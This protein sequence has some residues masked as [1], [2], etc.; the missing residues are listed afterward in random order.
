M[1]ALT[2]LPTRVSALSFSFQAWVPGK[3]EVGRVSPASNC[4][5]YSVASQMALSTEL[6]W[7]GGGELGLFLLLCPLTSYIHVPI[8]QMK[9][10]A[11]C[12]KII[13]ISR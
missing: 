8:V 9:C 13:K 1:P 2:I 11:P 6:A 12:L 3:V 7:E 4:Q 5:A 10:G